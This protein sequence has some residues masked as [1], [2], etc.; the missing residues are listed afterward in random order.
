MKSGIAFLAL[1]L[2]TACGAE[3][4]SNINEVTNSPGAAENVA[5]NVMENGAI[6]VNSAGEDVAAGE[7]EAAPTPT[8][9][10]AAPT[11]PS[12]ARQ[13]SATPPVKPAQDPSTRDQAG[14]P[15]A[16]APAPATS[17]TPKTACTPEHAAMGHCRP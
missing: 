16:P 3:P 8:A 15:A 11:T 4:A 10:T 14:A 9:K 13:R 2:V 1:A 17:P 7:S 5:V 12:P 6:E